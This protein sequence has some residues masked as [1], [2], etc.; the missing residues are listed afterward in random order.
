MST[1]YGLGKFKLKLNGLSH[2]RRG[3]VRA[4][5]FAAKLDLLVKA[6]RA[7]DKHVNGRPCFTH[8]IADLK[9][10]SAVAL[11]DEYQDTAN[12]G[13]KKSSV[14]H[15]HLIV[16][17]VNQG[18]GIPKDTPKAVAMFAAKAADGTDKSFDYGEASIDGT[19]DA[20]IRFDQH[21]D[22]KAKAAYAE[23][24]A[25]SEE[26]KPFDG[27]AFGTFDGYLLEVD[28]R[29]KEA[30][31]KLILHA[32][33]IEIDCLCGA[34]A[35]DHLKLAMKSRVTVHA[36]AHY[37]ESS[38]LPQHIDIR[39]IDIL[40]AEGHLSDWRG[41]FEGNPYPSADDIW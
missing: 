39:K 8:L 17:N 11:V 38:R 33:G 40:A 7:A 27:A 9:Y 41:A 1:Q 14:R 32:G 21:Y 35:T 30:T 20:V 2:E 26:I 37:S 34:I 29:G 31:A 5:V 15:V 16:D 3:S 24:V 6:L 19:D 23:Y 18:R 28:L 13:I 10:G 4:D 12:F 25:S 36:L 22:A